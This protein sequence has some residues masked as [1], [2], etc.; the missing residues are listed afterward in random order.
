MR[1]EIKIA[2]IALPIIFFSNLIIGVFLG[3]GDKYNLFN[4]VHHYLGGVFIA[5]LFY[6]YLYN[7]ITS[8]KV[9]PIEKWLIILSVTVFVG[10]VWEFAEWIG[11]YYNFDYLGIGDLE[12]TLLDL[13]ADLFG[14]I[15]LLILHPVRQRNS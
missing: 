15:T 12:D 7:V 14:A 9:R 5:L 13:V 6:G 2:L 4:T 8:R 10:V 11:T 3:I 1:K